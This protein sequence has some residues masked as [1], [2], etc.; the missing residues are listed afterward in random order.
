MPTKTTVTLLS[1]LC[2]MSLVEY[3][4]CIIDNAMLDITNNIKTRSNE[5]ITAFISCSNN[6]NFTNHKKVEYGGHYTYFCPFKSRFRTACECEVITIDYTA[7]FKAYNHYKDG[8]QC[9][10]RC[11]W[12]LFK[13]HPGLAEATSTSGNVSIKRREKWYFAP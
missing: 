4:E 11:K 12:F 3:S 10:P 9:I 1:L 7:Y 8:R 6:K 13:T 5:K 2:L